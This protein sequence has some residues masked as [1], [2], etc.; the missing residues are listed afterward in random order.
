MS[1][2]IS[3]E[4]ALLAIG[5]KKKVRENLNVN[6]QLATDSRKLSRHEKYPAY[7]VEFQ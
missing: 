3:G 7:G 6:Y 4:N 5:T 1:C 2:N